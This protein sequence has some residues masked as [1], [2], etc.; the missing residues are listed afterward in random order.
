MSECDG[1]GL[2]WRTYQVSDISPDVSSVRQNAV[3]GIKNK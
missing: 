1:R 3:S 2:S